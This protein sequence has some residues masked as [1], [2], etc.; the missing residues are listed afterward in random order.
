VVQGYIDVPLGLADFPVEISNAPRAWWGS[1]GPVVWSRSYEKGGNFAAWER[2]GDLV[3][4]LRYVLGRPVFL[5]WLVLGI[6]EDN[7]LSRNSPV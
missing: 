5:F 4:G 7:V 3:E 1:L 6:L 2:P